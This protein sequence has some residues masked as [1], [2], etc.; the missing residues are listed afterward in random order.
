MATQQDNEIQPDKTLSRVS[1][2]HTGLPANPTPVQLT[3][4]EYEVL[5]CMR[6][7]LTANEIAEKLFLSRRTVDLH[8]GNIYRKLS[9]KNRF[10]AVALFRASKIPIGSPQTDI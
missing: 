9:V 2:S 5:E 6:E 8:S 3:K 10:Q 1:P 7:G 4:R